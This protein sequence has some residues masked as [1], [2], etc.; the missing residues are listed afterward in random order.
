MTEYNL[1]QIIQE[2]VSQI[3]Q[4]I[5]KEEKQKEEEGEGKLSGLYHSF[6]MLFILLL[7]VQFSTINLKNSRGF[8]LPYKSW[9]FPPLTSTLLPPLHPSPFLQLTQQA[10]SYHQPK[11]IP[12][13]TLSSQIT[14]SPL[15]FFI[16]YITLN[17]CF[18]H[19]LNYCFP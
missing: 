9:L 15:V 2:I 17:F 12:P 16:N 5:K 19:N 11:S 6:V 7:T 14:P 18:Q 1:R 4:R 8:C 10:F 13:F 3:G